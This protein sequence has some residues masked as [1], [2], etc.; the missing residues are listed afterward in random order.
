[1]IILAISVMPDLENHGAESPAAPADS[2]QLLWIVVLLVDQGTPSRKSL[3]LPV[4]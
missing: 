1:M 4:D 2:A 3:L